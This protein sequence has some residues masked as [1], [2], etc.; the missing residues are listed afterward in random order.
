MKQLFRWINV[1]CYKFFHSPILVVHL[2]APLAGAGI[3][4]A[5]YMISPWAE[6]QKVSVYLQMLAMTFPVLIGVIVTM[7]EESEADAGGFQSALGAPCRKWLPHMAKILVLLF[8]GLLSSIIAVAGF[9]F[10]FRITGNVAFPMSFY[11]NGAG[12]LFAGYLP[13]YLLQY[14]ISFSFGKGAGLGLG[15]VGT[16]LSALMITGLG[17]KIWTF[18]PWSVSIRFVSIFTAVGDDPFLAVKG[19]A[20]AGL[21]LLAASMILLALLRY[22]S[23]KWEKQ[24]RF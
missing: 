4:L 11:M 10:A 6:V 7:S 21:F 1:E 14:L 3:F 18:L 19:V 2:L 16:L 22:W 15:I 8:F 17:D 20:A 24:T 9:G 23:V 5:Y 13:L 12:L